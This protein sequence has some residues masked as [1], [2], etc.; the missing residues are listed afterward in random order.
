MS[1]SRRCCSAA[2]SAARSSSIWCL[3]D[4]IIRD[5][6]FRAEERNKW[7]RLRRRWA[8]D[9]TICWAA[10]TSGGEGWGTTSV[11]SA[12]SPTQPIEVSVTGRLDDRPHILRSNWNTTH[13]VNGMRGENA[14]TPHHRRNSTAGYRCGYLLTPIGS[15]QKIDIVQG[16]RE[17]LGITAGR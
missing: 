4:G 15:A 1:A 13:G 5:T 8:I 16:V 14:C 2:S 11:S 9:Q 7:C 6:S 10:T 3:A 12:N 17:G